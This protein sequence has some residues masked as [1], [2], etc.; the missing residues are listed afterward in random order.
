VCGPKPRTRICAAPG[1]GRESTALCDF[2]IK[3]RNGKD[4]S[5]DRPM[6]DRHRNLMRALPAGFRWTKPAP[7]DSIDYCDEHQKILAG[8][9]DARGPL[10]QIYGPEDVRPMWSLQGSSLETAE[11]KV[12]HARPVVDWEGQESALGW[13]VHSGCI[14]EFVEKEKL[15]E[16]REAAET[17]LM[18]LRKGLT[19]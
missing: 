4:G 7:G 5:C 17:R 3:K 1:C 9:R 16:T 2:P 6:C 15:S 19:P 11:P 13:Y 18:S 14:R 10:V 8:Y 12:V